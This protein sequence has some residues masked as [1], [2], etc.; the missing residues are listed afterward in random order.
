M[1]RGS[2]TFIFARDEIFLE[3]DN[4][5]LHDAN[6]GFAPYLRAAPS[7]HGGHKAWGRE[8]HRLWAVLALHERVSRVM[9]YHSPALFTRGEISHLRIWSA[10]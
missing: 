3:L 9:A 6:N 1:R 2:S 7:G 5:R 10:G 8:T 4:E